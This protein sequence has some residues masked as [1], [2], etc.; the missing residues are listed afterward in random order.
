[1]LS[2]FTV[3]VLVP[4]VLDNPSYDSEIQSICAI[5]SVYN[6]KTKL[7]GDVRIFL[8]THSL[9]KLIT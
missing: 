5:I 4:L 9:S 1:M 3:K 7:E 8:K 6:L 2:W